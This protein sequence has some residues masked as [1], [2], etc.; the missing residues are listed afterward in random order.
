MDNLENKHLP[1]G[2]GFNLPN[3]DNILT[4][5]RLRSLKMILKESIVKKN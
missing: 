2:V 3:D 5:L 1:L 4:K